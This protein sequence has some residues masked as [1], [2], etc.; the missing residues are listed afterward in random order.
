MNLKDK[1]YEIKNGLSERIVTI[2]ISN[3]T[4]SDIKNAD[5]NDVLWKLE[6]ILVNKLV[7]DI[8]L[9]LETNNEFYVDSLIDSIMIKDSSFKSEE[10]TDNT[11]VWEIKYEIVLTTK[12]ES[13]RSL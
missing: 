2:P 9:E 10:S 8:N 13:K 1:H 7:N 6:N 11:S 3:E 12:Y 4:Y 5:I